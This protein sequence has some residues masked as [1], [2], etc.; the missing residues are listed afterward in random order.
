MPL[1]TPS[2]LPRQDGRLAVITGANSGIGL[3]AARMLTGAGAS[4]ILA[5]RRPDAAAAA[6]DQI[7]S[8]HP[9]AT[10]DTI[11]VDL[12]DLA[13]IAAA[14][15]ALRARLTAPIDYLVNNAG[16]FAP[17][18]RRITTDG[19]ELQFGVNH[20]G[21][22]A[23]TLPL[24]DALS[25]SARVV[26]VSSVA[27]RLARLHWDDLHSLRGYHGWV[28]YGRSKLANLLFM[29]ELD[30]R[31]VAG[32]SGAR[33]VAC[34]PGYTATNLQTAFDERAGL[35]HQ[36]KRLG[37][38]LIAQS[39]A[40]GAAPTVY[41]AVSTKV[42]G[43][44]YIGPSELFQLWGSPVKVSRSARARVPEDQARLWTASVEATGL[45]CP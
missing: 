9:E 3:E 26:Q 38:H 14:V 45:E 39:A 22:F 1:P 41:A 29:A 18:T 24:L 7:R 12:G 33:A 21:H 17:P 8:T 37:N 23:W 35:V 34:H 31:L 2:W 5:C 27:H 19:F 30:R 16:V 15:D 44:D 4:V 25:S 42:T 43:G 6:C 20:L 36:V 13:S 28:A 40:A 11:Q 32:G 10:L